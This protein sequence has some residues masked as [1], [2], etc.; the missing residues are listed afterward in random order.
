MD[1]TT[2][3]GLV[4]FC[5]V[6]S[7]TP[8]PNNLML[9]ASGATFGLRRTLPHMAGVTLGHGGMVLLVGVGLVGVFEAIP[10]AEIALRIVGTAYLIWLAWKIASAAPARPGGHGGRPFSFLQAALF[11]WVNPK[12]WTM[13]L[14]AIALYA[15]TRSVTAVA[16][17]AG[18]FTLV[19]APSVG[20]WAWAGE[21]LQVWLAAPRRLA[22]FNL[23]MALLLVA[24]LL[25]AWLI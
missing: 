8:G 25:P 5:F 13:A 11:Q 21:R 9:L 23:A 20:L 10:G 1:A 18:I 16:L 19:N 6:S 24:S 7:V 15:P 3:V 4:A 14:T 22:A 2:L 17:V 12:A